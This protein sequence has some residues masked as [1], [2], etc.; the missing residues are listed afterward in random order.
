[1]AAQTDEAC[2]SLGIPL[3][4]KPYRPHLTLARLKDTESVR[5]LRS[6]VAA[7]P[8]QD[9]GVFTATAFHLYSSVP[10]PGGSKYEK[11][12]EFPLT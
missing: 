1:M 8:Q 3:E 5:A 2:G 9:F 7:L 6:A 12:G 10:G 11:I 4:T